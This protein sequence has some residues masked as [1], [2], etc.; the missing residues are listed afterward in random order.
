MKKTSKFLITMLVA[1]A[2]LISSALPA[3]AV[4]TPQQKGPLHFARNG[5]QVV[6]EGVDYEVDKI[7]ELKVGEKVK[8]NTKDKGQSVF[9]QTIDGKEIISVITTKPIKDTG[10]SVQDSTWGY[11]LT[12]NDYYDNTY[13]G[14]G[15]LDTTWYTNSG[16]VTGI[17]NRGWGSVP[18]IQWPDKW[19]CDTIDKYVYPGDPYHGLSY[20]YLT[21]H[22]YILGFP[23][24]HS[25][26][27][28]ES[29]VDGYGWADSYV[30]LTERS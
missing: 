3:F 11:S 24:N 9:K 29:V 20:A 12:M 13:M 8:V 17:T 16:K 10:Y 2:T 6:V 27:Y 30:E 14:T 22:Y 7:P 5:N 21:D 18:A 25:T 4:D 28:F 26:Y 15:E 1:A 19:T 23:V